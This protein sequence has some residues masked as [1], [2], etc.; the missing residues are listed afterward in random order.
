MKSFFG[1]F[2]G[3]LFAIFLLIVVVLVGLIA[4]T[5]LIGVS[6]K[7]PTVA[8]NSLLVLDIA[9][10]ISD[11]PPEFNASQ[12]FAGLNESNRKPQLPCATFC[13]RSIVRRPIRR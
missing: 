9:V 2:F 10:P 11:A 8:D 7:G 3:A 12:L 1:S 4:V 13:E 5:V 6:E